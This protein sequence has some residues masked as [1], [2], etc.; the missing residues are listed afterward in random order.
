MPFPFLLAYAAAVLERAGPEID[1]VDALA[2]KLP[3]SSFVERV[4][5]FDPEVLILEISTISL[6]QDLEVVA[7]LRRRGFDRRVVL[8]GLHEPMYRP[9][10]LRAHPQV[11]AV[12]V[13]EYE[14]AARELCSAWS[15]SKPLSAPIP[16]VLYRDAGGEL[17]DGGR[18][19]LA[20]LDE[21]PWPARH[22]FNMSLYHDEPGSI[23]RP[24]VQMW[25]SR[26]CPFG[27]SF[28]AWPQILYGGRSYRHRD[29]RLVADEFEALVRAWGFRSVYFDDDTFNIRKKDVLELCRELKARRINV[30]WAAM[31]RADLMDEELLDTLAETGLAAVK[32]GVESGNQQLIKSC[33]KSLKLEKAIRNI[34]L[35]QEKGIKIH[36][37]FM[38]G[39]PGESRETAEETLDLAL[40]LAPES[41]QFTIATP[42]PGSR[43]HRELEERGL[44]VYRSTD[45]YDGFRRA[46]VH[47][48]HLTPEELEET[49]REANRRWRR[50]RVQRRKRA[51]QYPVEVSVVIPNYHQREA[52]LRCLRAL[53]AQSCDRFEVVLVDNGSRDDSVSAA[54]ELMP[55]VCA[56][57]S[58]ETLGFAAAVNRGISVARGRFVAVLNNDAEPEPE[59]LATVIREFAARPEVGFIA[60][61][62]VRR[63]DPDVVDSFGD[64]LSLSC[65]PFQV[66]NGTAAGNN[67]YSEPREVLGAPATAAVY[68]RELLDDVGGFDEDFETYLE[69]LDLS[70]RA[71]LRGWRCLAV[72]AARV[73]HQGQLT[74]GGVSNPAVVRLLGRN[75][76]QLLLKTVPR[77][78][79]RKY[80]VGIAGT[81]VRQL[82]Y[83]TLRSG[84]PVAYLMGI[85]QGLSRVRRLVA[86]RQSVLGWRQVDD[87][88]IEELLSSGDQLLRQTRASRV[89]G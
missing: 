79:L 73:R 49:V 39:L 53:D 27:C 89:A 52:L 86:K 80:A 70:L 37:T 84:H 63:A 13:G 1:C 19:P 22:R 76:V 35:T 26:G 67:G 56:L 47:S 64:G 33:N 5:R 24:S 85:L 74:T 7:S 2:E 48:G 81:G 75:W 45:H 32:Y 11:D 61:L 71:Q 6:D 21:L 66:G 30:P 59:W 50:L 40:R 16:G 77:H 17:I 46:A 36:L 15:G 51:R 41:L 82:F 12:L 57:E 44:L 78:I 3:L 55:D 8:C 28:C 10:F 38:F 23:P 62:V 20:V 42:F 69:D 54:R 31:C 68:R 58:D 14:L 43:Y 83:H 9:D 29:P 72:P 4:E 87:Q 88:R 60:S 18:R 25:A 65:F 34:L